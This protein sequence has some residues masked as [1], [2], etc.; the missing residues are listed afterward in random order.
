MTSLIIKD[1]HNIR[2][3]GN[4]TFLFKYATGVCDPDCL[5][6]C[7]GDFLFFV[8]FGL[9]LWLFLL[10]F[11]D[12]FYLRNRAEDLDLQGLNGTIH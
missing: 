8:R 9:L 5:M 4:Q 7:A 3:P 10:L 6:K 12:H 2:A 11:G 1:G